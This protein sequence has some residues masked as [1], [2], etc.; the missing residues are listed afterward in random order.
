MTRAARSKERTYPEIRS[1]NVKSR[2]FMELQLEM[3]RVE[4]V[5]M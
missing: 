2:E 4:G 5:E 3:E 1:E